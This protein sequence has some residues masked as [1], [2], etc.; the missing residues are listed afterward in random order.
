M[1]NNRSAAFNLMRGGQLVSLYLKMAKEVIVLNFRYILFFVFLSTCFTI[2]LFVDNSKLHHTALYGVASFKYGFWGSKKGTVVVEDSKGN[3]RVMG[4]PEIYNTPYFKRTYEKTLTRA[5]HYT[6]FSAVGTFI[7]AFAWFFYLYRKGYDEGEDEHI[8][9]GKLGDIKSHNKLVEKHEK[10]RGISSDLDVFGAK[11][12][13]GTD[14]VNIG[15]AGQP[16][17]GKSTLLNY[18]FLQYRN[19]GDK[20]FVLDVG[21]ALTEKFYRDGKDIILSPVDKRSHYWDVWQEGASSVNYN[22]TS[23]SLISEVKTGSGGKSSGDFFIKAARIIFNEMCYKVREVAINHKKEEP[24]LQMFSNYLLRISDTA[25]IQ[26]VKNTDARA[27]LNEDAEG[28]TA[29]IR[30]TLVTYCQLLSKL[31]RV[32]EKFSFNKWVKSEDDSCVFIPI[33][34]ADRIYFGP[35]I[36][37]WVEHY[38][39]AVLRLPEEYQKTQRHQLSI[40]ELAGYPAIP[41]LPTFLSEARKRRGNANIGFQNKPQIDAIYGKDISNAIE[42]LISTWA[43]YRTGG[44]VDSAWASKMLLSNEQVKNRESFSIG[45]HEVRDSVGVNKDHK[46]SY[47]LVIPSEI[48]NLPD[49]VFYLR[50]GRGYPIL[51]IKGSRQEIENI[52]VA[53]DRFTDEEIE[54]RRYLDDR[55]P[56]DAKRKEL[57]QNNDLN[58]IPSPKSIRAEDVAEQPKDEYEDLPS[59]SIDVFKEYENW[60]ERHGL[61]HSISAYEEFELERQGKDETNKNTHPASKPPSKQIKKKS[62]NLRRDL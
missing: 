50:F 33:D 44:N 35:I 56:Q 55:A 13:P 21:G 61:P 17:V 40:D 24:T 22:I 60:L 4:W 45:S 15:M 46:E 7:F 9:G 52:S 49:L 2:Y 62:I 19:A 28:M 32:G 18:L 8:R 37:M 53:L 43:I 23:N 39:I 14:V 38:V 3:K 16:S 1:T 6:M 34:A 30:S 42:G 36:S 12:P 51:K 5:K 29:S 25:L 41:S 54:H 27:V 26:M 48:V 47:S 31:P 11:L 20:C 58:E 59:S 10:E 57:I